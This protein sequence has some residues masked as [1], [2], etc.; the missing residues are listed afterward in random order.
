MT[1]CQWRFMNYNWSSVEG[2]WEAGRL[3]VCGERGYMGNLFAF[4][5]ILPCF[6]KALTNYLNK[7]SW[8]WLN[9]VCARA[10]IRVHT[11][12]YLRHTVLLAVWQAPATVWHCRHAPCL[13]E[14]CR[15]PHQCSCPQTK[16]LS[17]QHLHRELALYLQ[18]IGLCPDTLWFFERTYT[19]FLQ[20]YLG[21]ESFVCLI[22]A[23][24]S[25]FEGTARQTQQKMSLRCL[26]KRETLMTKFP[27]K[28]Y[29][30]GE[31]HNASVPDT[32]DD[33][34]VSR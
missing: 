27:M 14:S 15:E 19:Q 16:M 17:Q 7:K 10:H 32:Q 5:S 28:D 8:Y 12:V 1:M 20:S 26:E 24:Y 18:W 3:C 4:P 29:S 21:E 25:L 13:R 34:A 22:S 11:H 33:V 30:E 9:S 6:L 23:V 2:C 31:S